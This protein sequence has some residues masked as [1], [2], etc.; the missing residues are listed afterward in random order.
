M[1]RRS[2][3]TMFAS[4]AAV[5]LLAVGPS[6]AEPKVGAPAPAFSA[7]NSEG[8]TVNLSDY[9]GKTV[10]LEWTN[11]G[12]PVCPQALRQRQHAGAAEEVDRPG[13]RLAVRHLLAARRTGLCRCRHAPIR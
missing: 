11:D 10:V 12:C 8:K 9:S 5:S 3:A 1:N 4:A 2:F 13:H 7:V 6:Q